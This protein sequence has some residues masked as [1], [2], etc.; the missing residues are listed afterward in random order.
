V[1]IPKHFFIPEIIEKRKPLAPRARRV[2]WIGCNILLETIPNSGKIFYIK[3]GKQQSK[4]KIL[5]E[6]NKTNFLK[7]S[8]DLKS[9]SWILD[10]LKCIEML[11]KKRFFTQ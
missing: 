11:N 7:F 2:G 3:E 6:W 8:H 10:I 5:E 9:K 4:D 1:V